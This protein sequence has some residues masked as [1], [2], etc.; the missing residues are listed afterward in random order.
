MGD[1]EAVTNLFY[2]VVNKLRSLKIN[3]IKNMTQ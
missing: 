1:F 2:V 3:Q